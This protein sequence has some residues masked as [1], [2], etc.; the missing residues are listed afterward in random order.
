MEW[1]GNKEGRKLG[2]QE[3]ENGL[4]PGQHDDTKWNEEEPQR[5]Q[6]QERTDR[7]LSV[8]IN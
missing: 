1:R 3:T 2:D 4:E 8:E 5:R 6:D 7:T